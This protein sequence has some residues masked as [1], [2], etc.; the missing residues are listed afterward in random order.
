MLDASTAENGTTAPIDTPAF[1]G[2]CFQRCEWCG[3]PSFHRLLCPVCASSDL[4]TEH[5]EGRGVVRRTTVLH[6]GTLSARNESLIEMAEGF[7]VRGRV[8]GPPAAI[9]PGDR[10]QLSR[11]EDPVRRE[12]LFQ[13]MDEPYRPW[14]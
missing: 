6:R 14:A 5:S 10:V 13:L 9:H 8:L 7:T 12:P 2:L 4:R 3:T 11:A 1:D